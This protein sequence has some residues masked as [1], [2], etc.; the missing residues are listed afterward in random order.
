MKQKEIYVADDLL[1]ILQL[2]KNKLNK[3]IINYQ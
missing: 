1:K 2:K 3:I